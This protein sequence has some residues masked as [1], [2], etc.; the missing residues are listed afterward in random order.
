[1]LADEPTGNLDHTT[2]EQVYELMLKL[3][4]EMGTS[5]VMVTHDLQLASRMSRVL[6]LEDGKLQ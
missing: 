4:E 6:H 1:M 3:N 2:A 5:I